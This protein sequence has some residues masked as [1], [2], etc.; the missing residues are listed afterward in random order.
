MTKPRRVFACLVATLFSGATMVGI[1]YALMCHSRAGPGISGYVSMFTMMFISTAAYA[2]V[3]TLAYAVIAA[4]LILEGTSRP[5]REWTLGI[6][7]I[8]LTSTG[9]QM[10]MDLPLLE[11]I[12]MTGMALVPGSVGIVRLQRIRERELENQK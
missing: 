4:G 7:L 6:G 8:V 12:P 3:P 5:L 9:I 11:T 1:L 2:F 10:A